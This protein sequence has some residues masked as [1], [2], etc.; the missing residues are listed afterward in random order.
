M[1]ASLL[2]IA[3]TMAEKWNGP[4]PRPIPVMPDTVTADN[5]K[6]EY[7]NRYLIPVGIDNSSLV[8]AFADMTDNYCMLITGTIGSGKSKML[9]AIAKMTAEKHENSEIFVF[10]GL[11]ESLSG[12]KQTAKEY[13]VCNDDE[14]VSGQLAYII[15]EL[16][17]RLNA[18]KEARAADEGSFDA[19]KFISEYNIIFIVIDDLKEFV[20]S[21]S[22]NNKS[23]ME[24]ICRLA[25][26]FGVIVT[27]AGRMADIAKFNEIET[28]TR[29]IVSYQNGIAMNGTPAQHTYFSNDLKYNE[30]DSE[31]GE[32]FGYLF[33]SGKC[34]KIKLIV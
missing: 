13:C 23:R 8:T 3:K 24:R 14:K 5:L 34:R 20:E 12:L 18:Q 6:N 32:G 31:A 28:L 30:R 2:E 21:V 27:A 26:D 33:S 10:D 1:N 4:L 19:K 7:N 25:T 15:S 11:S 16:N 22:D 9:S 29:L 17:N